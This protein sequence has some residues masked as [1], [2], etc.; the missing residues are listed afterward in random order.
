MI[1]SFEK[2]DLC[3]VLQLWLSVNLEVHSFVKESYWLEHR[4]TVAAMMLEADIYVWEEQGIKGF[5]GLMDTYIAGL[6][7]E[8]AYRGKGIGRKLLHFAFQKHAQLTLDVYAEN[9]A[10]IRFYEREGF[11]KVKEYEEETT[12]QLTYTMTAKSMS[13]LYG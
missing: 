12:K 6:F 11:V 5:L 2:E 9:K 13:L 3:E 1:R 4:D 8:K 7:V 10:A